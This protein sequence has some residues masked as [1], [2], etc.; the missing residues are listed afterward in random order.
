MQT[1]KNQFLKK[2]PNPAHSSQ[3]TKENIPADTPLFRIIPEKLSSNAL[4]HP[5][6]GPGFSPYLSMLF[7]Q[8][9]IMQRNDSISK[10][11]FSLSQEDRQWLQTFDQHIQKH[12]QTLKV[13]DLA[14]AFAMSESTL[15]RQVK[16]LTGMTPARYLRN[17]RLQRAQ[18]LLKTHEHYSIEKLAA[19]VGYKDARAF[20]RS[21]K[22]RFGR[23]PSEDL[24]NYLNEK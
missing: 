21:Y 18:H 20:S 23:F 11:L 16:R 13:P 4:I 14:R 19:K 17:K 6:I 22:K 5:G 2:Q 7:V 1:L 12:L 24:R 8:P 9:L 15:L 10:P 3:V